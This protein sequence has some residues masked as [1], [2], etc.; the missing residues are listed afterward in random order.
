MIRFDKFKTP[1]NFKIEKYRNWVSDRYHMN[2]QFWFSR[3]DKELGEL[4][5]EKE[6]RLKSLH[7]EEIED[8]TRRLALANDKLLTVKADHEDELER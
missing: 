1:E 5:K 8:L 3:N 2:T 4:Y 7:Q 6:A